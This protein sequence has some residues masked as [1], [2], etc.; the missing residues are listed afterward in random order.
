MYT[1]SIES[2]STTVRLLAP[3]AAPSAAR[4][5]ASALAAACFTLVV[6][7]ST[8]LRLAPAAPAV[9]AVQKLSYGVR[10][11][12]RPAYALCACRARVPRDARHARDRD[13]VAQGV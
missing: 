2:M 6:L 10:L 13:W 1:A 4:Q 9:L 8:A 5:R 7:S 12:R 11:L 3:S